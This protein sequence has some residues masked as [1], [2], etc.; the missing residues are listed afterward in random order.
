MTTFDRFDPFE[1]RISEAV[2]EIA[3]ARPLD[4]LDD[5]FRQTARTSQRPRWTFPERWFNVDTTLSRP[6]VFGRLPL[7]Q[8]V[9]LALLLALAAAALTFYV[10]SARPA[11]HS[12]PRRM[13]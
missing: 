12:G 9:V 6:T 10:G 4:Y 3:D 2:D 13:A 8:L 1:R 11:P 7:R 5:I